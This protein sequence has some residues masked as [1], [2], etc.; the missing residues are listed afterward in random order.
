M[1][2]RWLRSEQ[3]GT[4]SCALCA[5]LDD[6][7]AA[8]SSRSPGR[9]QGGR[10]SPSPRVSWRPGC[11]RDRSGGAR[12]AELEPRKRDEM[13][14][15]FHWYAVNTKARGPC[16]SCGGEISAPEHLCF[17]D[18]LLWTLGQPDGDRGLRSNR[19]RDRST[20]QLD[21]ASRLR[22]LTRSPLA[23]VRHS[24]APAHIPPEATAR[25]SRVGA[26]HVTGA[27]AARG[28]SESLARGPRA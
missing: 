25:S 26:K 15:C 27:G 19:G 28:T 4:G 23:A 7:P 14:W 6:G 22:R 17:E 3:S 10:L 16:V 21:R 5:M 13:Y 2:A 18:R 11:D 1:A 12:C 8:C 24:R 9:V 20:L